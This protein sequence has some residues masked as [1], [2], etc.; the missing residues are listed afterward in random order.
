ME[1]KVKHVLADGRK[2]DSIEG[3]VIPNT[4]HASVVYQIAAQITDRRLRGCQSSGTV[5]R[6]CAS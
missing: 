1:I 5:M 4:G 2:L 6:T 3:F